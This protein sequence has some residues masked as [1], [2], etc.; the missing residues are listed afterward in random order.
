MSKKI[1][2]IPAFKVTETS[3]GCGLNHLEYM[4]QY[5]NIRLLMPTDDYVEGIDLLYLPG[6]MDLNPSSYGEVPA[7][8]CSHTD[9]FKQHFYDHKLKEYIESGVPIF[10]VCL[11]FQMLA[12]Y[13]RSKL[14]QNLIGHPQSKDRWEKGH[15]V[16]ICGTKRTFD[17]NSHH[18]QG[19]LLDN[20]SDKLL[21]IAVA[22]DNVV[23]AFKHESLSISA[24]QFHCEEWYDDL[25]KQLILDLLK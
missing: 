1:I 16:T 2:G 14:T 13:F 12:V 10:G 11:G 22:E 4:S 15:K 18:H 21:P 20:L 24:V 8:K 3:F 25:S 19:I 6:G 5:G 17:V 9:V 7:Y 23:E